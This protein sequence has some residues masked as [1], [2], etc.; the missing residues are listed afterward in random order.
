MAAAS[1][2][3][4]V[5]SRSWQP[6]ASSSRRS[7]SRPRPTASDARAAREQADAQAEQARELLRAA[8]HEVQDT[9]R[10]SARVG[11]ELAAANQFLR[12]HARVGGR[13][14]GRQRRSARNCA[15]RTAMSW[16]WRPRSG[17]GWT[18]RSCKDVARRGGGARPGRS[19]RRHGAACRAR[20][21]RRRR[22]ALAAGA[23]RRRCQGRSGCSICSAAPRR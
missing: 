22:A 12:G 15:C 11:A 5:S 14:P 21:A 17:A 4:S 8:E 7:W 23:C 13:R 19:G 9:R 18:R 2:R 1:R 20:S 16:R 10:E 3:S 6:H